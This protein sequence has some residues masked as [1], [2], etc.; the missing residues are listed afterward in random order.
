MKVLKKGIL[1]PVIVVVLV[2][3]IAGLF[4]NKDREPYADEYL[5]LTHAHAIYAHGTFGYNFPNGID[6]P[7]KTGGF[8]APAY[9]AFV[10]LMMHL[11]EGLADNVRCFILK[12]LKKG[13]GPCSPD[14][15][16]VKYVQLI[17]AGISM[18][19]IWLTARMITSSWAIASLAVGVSL[20]SGA[21]LHYAN[22]FLTEAIYVPLTFI[23]LGLSVSAL[24]SPSVLRFAMAGGVL[25]LIAITRPNYYYLFFFLIPFLPISWKFC[26]NVSLK[27]FAVASLG[28]ALAFG[29]ITGPWI[30]RNAIVSNSATIS[31]GYG[32]RTLSGRVGF[33]EVTLKEYAAAW[34]YW[35]PDFG[36]KMALSVFGAEGIERLRV[37]SPTG[38]VRSVKR[39]VR[40]EAA[41][42]TGASNQENESQRGSSHRNWLIKERV[43]GDFPKHVSTTFVLAW[44]GVFIENYFGMAGLIAI[45]WASFLGFKGHMRREFLIV[46][47]PALIMLFF[48]A[49]VSL[50]SPRYNLPLMLSMSIAIGSGLH[51]YGQA[52]LLRFKARG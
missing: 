15:G 50:N 24:R 18:S 4:V 29:S 9:P 14:F 1:V 12:V 51:H 13:P 3:V 7:P 39:K 44:R 25:G 52:A 36:D 33:N 40:I 28:F 21:P 8:V 46:L 37:A 41:Q 45:V 42:A 6:K 26:T 17:I 19:A 48:N 49:F 10:A 30:V 11:D 2:T 5:Y 47:A 16:L 34:L 22:Y 35:I 32:A 38:F 23:F 31:A 20:M 43:F 27:S